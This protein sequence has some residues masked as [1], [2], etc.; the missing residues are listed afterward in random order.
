MENN[1]RKEREEVFSTAVKAGKRTYFFD[2]K[3]TVA[4]DRYM[5]VTESKRKFNDE[6]GTFSYEK[7]KI[8]LYKEDFGKFI[9]ALNDTIQFIETGIAPEHPEEKSS[10]NNEPS[11]EDFDF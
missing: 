4:G 5:T 2:V 6:D 9:R 1:E 10:E 3:E 7:H 11:L 8:F